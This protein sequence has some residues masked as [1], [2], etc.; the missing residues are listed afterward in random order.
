MGSALA[1]ALLGAGHDV[2]V[3]NRSTARAEPLR[4]AGASVATRA[5]EAAREASIVVVCVTDYAATHLALED[6]PLQGKLLVQLSTGTPQE[7]RTT[8]RWARTRGA[9]YLD[10]AIMAVP[11]QIGKPE[12]TI[13]LAGPLAAY[14]RGA[15]ALR[16][17]AGTLLH[18]G[19]DAGAASALDF[20]F[21]SYFFGGLMGFYHGARI[22][23]VEGLS[24]EHYGQL[25]LG[26]ASALGAMV[27]SD[28]TNIEA[29][30][31][32]ADDATLDICARSLDLIV[33]HADEA[34]LD[35]QVPQAL[36]TFF[37]RGRAAG[38][39]GE[40]PAALVKVLRAS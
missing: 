3:W 17:L 36:A 18:V 39:G 19:S 14:E 35:R 8:E 2:V 1:K 7:A 30:N 34:G 28:A 16:S 33:R 10:G 38:F 9:D 11:R 22:C 32:A 5:S 6:V 29:G 24:V 37:D 20:A 13:L 23:E 26:S 25:L 12:S 27:A 40:G 15:D 4:V 31:Y 21:L